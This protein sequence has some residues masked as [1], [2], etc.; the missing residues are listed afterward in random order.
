MASETYP[1]R[2]LYFEVL[3]EQVDGSMGSMFYVSLM[4]NQNTSVMWM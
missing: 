4:S 2:F 3:T 1:V